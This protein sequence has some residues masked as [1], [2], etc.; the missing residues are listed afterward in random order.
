MLTRRHFFTG[1]VASAFLP[2]VRPRAA[3]AREASDRAHRVEFDLPILAEDPTTVPV[4]VS[5]DHPMEADHF[6]RSLEIRLDTDPIPQKGTFF[7]TPVNG[8]ASVAFQMRS[9]VGGVV[10]V[11]GECTR[12]GRFQGGRRVR[13]AEGGCT[14]AP[15]KLGRAGLGNPRIRMP[16][17]FRAG[18]V[19]EVR[20]KVDH[21]SYTGLAL[22]DGKFV[23]ELPAF[24][25]KQMLVFLDNRKVSE[26]QMSSA[27]SPNPLIRFP[28]RASRR[29]TLR[30][31]FVNSVG[32]RWEATQ[33]LRPSA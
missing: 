2:P 8:R 9:G 1:I 6:I 16:R 14:T 17:S 19:M 28:L 12:H 5:V 29:A 33:V 7:F 23:R 22:K 25:V 13:V 18:Q 11:V 32:Q 10:T 21:N 27:V 4:E 26:F 3:G 24:Y 31:V 15:E 30:I 20:T